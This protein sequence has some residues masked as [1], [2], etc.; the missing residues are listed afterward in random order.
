MGSA[1]FVP[2]LSRRP[3]LFSLRILFSFFPYRT[4]FPPSR[5]KRLPAARIRNHLLLCT[6]IDRNLLHNTLVRCASLSVLFS[7]ATKIHLEMAG[8]G[9][10]LKMAVGT[11]MSSHICGTEVSSRK[12]GL[13][14]AGRN[15]QFAGDSANRDGALLAL[16]YFSYIDGHF[17]YS[18]SAVCSDSLR[19]IA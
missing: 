2:L 4:P 10:Y 12:M 11:R 19:C 16:A 3:L 1:R 17:G 5:L 8:R 13:F 15:F 14:W 6:L 9:H 18:G 7:G